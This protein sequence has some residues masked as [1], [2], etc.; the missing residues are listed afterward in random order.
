MSVCVKSHNPDLLCEFEPD[1]PSF[2]K[3]IYSS[4]IVVS[5][6]RGGIAWRLQCI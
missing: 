3:Y 6:T 4:A 2:H 1:F 5:T